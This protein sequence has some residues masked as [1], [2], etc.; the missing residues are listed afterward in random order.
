MLEIGTLCEILAQKT[1]EKILE[2]TLSLLGNCC[3]KEVCCEK[4]IFFGVVT[5]LISILSSINAPSVLFRA[6]RLLG[7]LSQFP[8][9]QSFLVST[10]ASYVLDG[11]LRDTNQSINVHTMTIR[12]VRQLWTQKKFRTEMMSLGVIRTIMSILK[13]CLKKCH[14]EDLTEEEVVEKVF[15]LTIQ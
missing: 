4:A 1:N 5:T 11:L 10:N 13:K 14:V 12:A 15:S 3:S 2:V 6:C 7:N 9:C 8:K